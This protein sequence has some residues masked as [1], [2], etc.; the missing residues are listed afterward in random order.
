LP[1]RCEPRL[2][3][4][5]RPLVLLALAITLLAAGLYLGLAPTYVDDLIPGHEQANC[6]SAFR[7][8]D[9]CGSGV[10]TGSLRVPAI[11]LLVAALLCGYGSLKARHQTQLRINRR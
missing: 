5:S 3:K 1:T 7:P 11:V 4:R 2:V 6:G 10:E 8:N 9:V